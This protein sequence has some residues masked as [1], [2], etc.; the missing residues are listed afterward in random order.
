MSARTAQVVNYRQMR[1]LPLSV[2]VRLHPLVDFRS[3]DPIPTRFSFRSSSLL[4]LFQNS[5][6]S[7]EIWR[8][9]FCLECVVKYRMLERS[10]GFVQRF[11]SSL[12]SWE[13][14]VRVSTFG[15]PPLWPADDCWMRRS[16]RRICSVLDVA[17]YLKLSSS[18]GERGPSSQS[19][20][21]DEN[22]ALP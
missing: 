4:R 14:Y 3:L 17:R 2:L 20:Y 16:S 9:S 22:G 15:I 10:V 8:R 21:R 11:R 19:R 12:E 5:T 13:R 18:L 6:A 1:E 7:A